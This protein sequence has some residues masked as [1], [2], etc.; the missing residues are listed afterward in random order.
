M[1]PNGGRDVLSHEA[2]RSTTTDHTALPHAQMYPDPTQTHFR[3]VSRAHVRA[4]QCEMDVYTH[5]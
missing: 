2:A 4:Y 1:S 5:P 3:S